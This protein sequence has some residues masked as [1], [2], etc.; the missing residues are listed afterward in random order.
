MTLLE[1]LL[2][3]EEG[4]RRSAYTDSLGF[5]TIGIGRLIDAKKGGGVTFDEALYLLR[6]DIAAKEADLRATLP[7]Y[8]ALDPVR[9]T[10]LASMAF[11]LGTAGLFAFRNTLEAVAQGRYSDAAEG[12]MRS[13]WARQ[14]PGRALRLAEAMRTG[15]SSSFR[16]DEEPPE[17]IR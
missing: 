9:R 3:R 5:L 2:L 6:N 10:V 13:L 14:T 15:D 8:D 16:L 1:K 4:Y 12:M 11:Q 17:P 7:W